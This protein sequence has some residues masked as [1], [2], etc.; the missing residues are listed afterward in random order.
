MLHDALTSA[1]IPIE[2]EAYR[3]RI[4]RLCDDLTRQVQRNTADL[5]L[6][7]D[8]ILVDIL[9]NTQLVARIL[10]LLSAQLASPIL[11]TGPSDRLALIFVGWLHQS[12][13]ATS[14]YAPIVSDDHCAVWPFVELNPI[15]FL[16]A[17][18]Q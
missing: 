3:V 13:T 9:S 18:E 5:A 8:E 4:V 7:R 1:S 14:G 2:L 11:Q 10:A 15:Y 17:V 16:P 6:G 12:Q